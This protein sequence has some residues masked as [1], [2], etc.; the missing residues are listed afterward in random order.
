MLG[1]ECFCECHMRWNTLVK[2]ISM[3]GLTA[4]RDSTHMVP[5]MSL[6]L[7]LQKPQFLDDVSIHLLQTWSFAWSKRVCDTVDL[8]PYQTDLGPENHL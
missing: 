3:H 4:L 2:T 8:A 5:C 6:R 1:I 7:Q